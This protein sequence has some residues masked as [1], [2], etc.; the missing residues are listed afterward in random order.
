[1]SPPSRA[2]ISMRTGS[3]FEMRN[4]MCAAPKASPT[5]L[6]Q[7]RAAAST[8]P[9][10]SSETGA[11]KACPTSTQ[12]GSGVTIFFVM[13]SMCQSEPFQRSSTLNSGPST[14]S[15]T[16]QVRDSA[17]PR[18]VS[19]FSRSARTASRKSSRDRQM[20]TPTLA[21]PSLGLTTHGYPTGESLISASTSNGTLRGLSPVNA[22][23]L[24]RVWSL[25]RVRR[26]SARPAWGSPKRIASSAAGI[27]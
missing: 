19:H 27:R 22:R 15:S 25:W 10:T 11:G 2:L 21:V 26:S 17:Y 14:N 23:M 7:R 8:I 24:A 4:S 3:P 1:M 9:R 6:S 5:A 16:S 20:R 13:P 18:T 12:C